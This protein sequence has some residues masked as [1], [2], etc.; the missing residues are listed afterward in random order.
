MTIL[1][2]PLFKSSCI[3]PLHPLIAFLNLQFMPR[4]LINPLPLSFANTRRRHEVRTS[5][6]DRQTLRNHLDIFIPNSRQLSQQTTFHST[7]CR[8]CGI[9]FQSDRVPVRGQTDSEC[10]DAHTSF[11]DICCLWIVQST[12]YKSFAIGQQTAL[13]TL[14]S[15][16]NMSN[17][18]NTTTHVTIKKTGTI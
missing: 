10:L 1:H 4:F 17:D 14:K 16:I 18:G 8:V 12:T 3:L 9:D 13:N 2:D 11:L 5:D 7:I 15:Q 6:Q